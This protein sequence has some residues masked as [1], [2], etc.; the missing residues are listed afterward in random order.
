MP[1]YRTIAAGP[2]ILTRSDFMPFMETSSVRLHYELEGRAEAPCLVLSNSLGTDLGMWAPQMPALLQHF[3][4]LRYD[5]RGHGQSG[6][7][8]GPY[9]IAQLGGDVIALMDHVKIE[10]AHFCGLSMGGMIGM[11]LGAHHP[12][13][14]DHL[15]LSNTGAR[16]GSPDL[17]NARID[18]VSNEGLAAIVPAVLDRWF[19]EGFR[20]RA[21]QT[22]ANVEHMLLQTPAAGYAACCAAVRDMD[23]REG[24]A[25]IRAATLVIAGTQDKATSPADGHL[26]ADRIPGAQYVEFDAAH[27]SNCEV[28]EAFTAAL[29]KFLTQGA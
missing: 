18:K 13:R 17:W 29:V 2:A 20:T 7:T 24:L 3:R 27:L 23:Q 10:K 12:A 4:V 5:T 19:T 8:P 26:I 9:S 15:V 22:V 28:P 14:I 25:G 16:I 6:V 21:P 1:F 11:W